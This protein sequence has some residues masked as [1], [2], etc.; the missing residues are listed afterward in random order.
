MTALQS[1]Y[2]LWW[3][4]PEDEILPTLRG[5]RHRLRAVQPARQGLPH[6]HDRRDHHVR[7]RRHPQH[8][9]RASTPRRARPTRP[10]STCSA[11]HRGA[12]GRHAGPDRARLAAGPEAVDRAD[13]RH[14]ASVSGWRRTSAPPTSSSPPTTSARS[15]PL[16][17]R[18]T[19]QGDRYPEQMQRM[20]DRWAERECSEHPRELRGGHPRGVTAPR[21][22]MPGW[23]DGQM[24][25]HITGDEHADQVLT[26]F[27]V[28]PAVPACS[29]MSSSR[30]SGPSR[31]P[32]KVLDRFGTPR[33]EPGIAAAEPEQFASLCAEPP[34]SA[35]VPGLDGRSGSRLVARIVVEDYDGLCGAHLDRGDRRSTT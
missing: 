4:E 1:E 33:A 31:G 3:R 26:D 20:I 7:Q 23:H 15:T 16:P 27:T 9:S 30:W 32:A 10:W 18:S 2:S 28:C 19:V 17:R 8:A 5:A 14:H 6:R 34:C 25:I 13:P 35:P 29:W 22:I 24:A 11:R 12:Q 21:R